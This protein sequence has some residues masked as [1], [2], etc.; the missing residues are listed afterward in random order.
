MINLSEE[1]NNHGWPVWSLFYN[2]IVEQFGEPNILLAWLVMCASFVLWL[3]LRVY[4]DE[5]LTWVQIQLVSYKRGFNVLAEIKSPELPQLVEAL[6]DFSFISCTQS[7]CAVKEQSAVYLQLK[8][9]KWL[10]LDTDGLEKLL[11]VW[12]VSAPTAQLLGLGD[13]ELEGA[14]LKCPDQIVNCRM[15][16]RWSLGASQLGH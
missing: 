15:L 16:F 13:V 4:K 5:M 7:Q 14:S 3:V 1:K 10:H 9:L 6:L 11:W 8:V 12:F 2:P